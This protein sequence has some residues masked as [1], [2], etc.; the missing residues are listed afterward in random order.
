MPAGL[1]W[2][3]TVVGNSSTYGLGSSQ[4]FYPDIFRNPFNI[5]ISVAVNSTGITFSVESTMDYNGFSSAFI[6]TAANWFPNSGL[7]AQTSG[8]TGNYAYPVTAI[9]LNV[10]AGSSTG[11]ATITCIQAGGI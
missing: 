9:R 8:G 3:N 2:R 6:S 11:T 5:G 4:C 1:V 10:T 7:T